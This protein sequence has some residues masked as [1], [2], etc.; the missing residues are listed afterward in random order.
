M[1]DKVAGML[2]WVTR[3]KPFWRSSIQALIIAITY[4]FASIGEKVVQD[5]FESNKWQK[6][7]FP[8][9]IIIVLLISIFGFLY[10]Y[11]NSYIETARR[12]LESRRNTLLYAYSLI[13]QYTV[14]QVEF[15]DKSLLGMDI[16]PSGKM[17]I[18]ERAKHCED[19]ILTIMTTISGLSEIVNGIYSV[20]ESQYGRSEQVDNRTDFEVTFMTKSYSDGELTIP[21]Y[22][23][24]S[25]RQPVSMS[26]RSS[27]REIYRKT[28][29]ASVYNES[30]PRMRIIPDTVEPSTGYTE[31]Y[32]GQRERIRSTLIFPVMCDKNKILG[33][34]VVHCNNPG[35][36]Q[37]RDRRFWMELLEIFGKRIAVEKIRLDAMNASLN[38]DGTW[39]L[40]EKKVA[41]PF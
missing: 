41:V 30:S 3:V 2:G 37:E 32:A 21:A 19:G 1:N 29:S 22:A 14:R 40:G 28:I 18:E 38:R 16:A 33:T 23:N 5:I 24:R 36:F 12:E 26:H 9:L 4:I 6:G 27:D 11:V 25:R 15:L 35:F 8:K 20:F 10:N 31:L 7:L 13:D 34:L 39:V 17:A